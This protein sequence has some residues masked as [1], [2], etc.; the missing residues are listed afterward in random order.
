MVRNG[1]PPPDNLLPFAKRLVA[2]LKRKH[3]L[4]MGSHRSED[5]CHDLYV[6]GPKVWRETENEGFARNR[7][8]DR[9][10]NLLRDFISEQRHEPKPEGDFEPIHVASLEDSKTETV[11]W[12]EQKASASDKW[13]RQKV[14][15]TEDILN[16]RR[17]LAKV[18][19]RVRRVCECIMDDMKGRQI[20]RKIGVSVRTVERDKKAFEKEFIN[21]CGPPKYLRRRR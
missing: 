9:S 1:K 21:E 19:D 11:S 15:K 12:L 13:S 20:A 14:D 10:K 4:T 8:A 5:A 18:P 17:T 3:G 2:K 7:M 6:E 16:V